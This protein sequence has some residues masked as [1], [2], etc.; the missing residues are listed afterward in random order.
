[1]LTTTVNPYQVRRRT[2][3]LTRIACGT[4]LEEPR[5]QASLKSTWEMKRNGAILVT[6]RSL[7]PINTK[8]TFTFRY[9]TRVL[10]ANDMKLLFL[11]LALILGVPR[12]LLGQSGSP[13]Q[14]GGVNEFNVPDELRECLLV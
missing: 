14:M 3:P 10:R 11:L 6:F 13:D 12:L 8:A 5:A 7:Q 9:R 4:S 1:M 2:D